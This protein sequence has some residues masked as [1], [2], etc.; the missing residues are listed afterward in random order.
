LRAGDPGVAFIPVGWTMLYLFVFLKLPIVAA[1]WL[2]WWAVHQEPDYSE[3]QDD[4]GGK[5]RLHP[6][7]KLPNAPRRGSHHEPAPPPPA[8][9]RSVVARDRELQG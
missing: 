1:A 2:I 9:V 5:R 8:R 3:D 7:S 6:P 4:G